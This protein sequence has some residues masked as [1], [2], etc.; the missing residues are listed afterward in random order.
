MDIA[1][2]LRDLGLERYEADFRENEIDWAVLP[3]LTADDLK[4]IGVTAVGHLR[5][6]LQAIAQLSATPAP[7]KP[8]PPGGSPL[9]T[10]GTPALAGGRPGAPLTGLDPGITGEGRVAAAA[11]A[12]R[13]QLTIMFCDL[14]GSTPLSSRLDPEDLRDVIGAYRRAVTE[15]IGAHH[16][17]VAEVIGTFEGFVAKYMGDGVLAYFGYPRG[18]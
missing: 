9:P 4:D 17:A 11:E 2:W 1:G 8:I 18:P 6:L 14:V 12:E 16:R 15:V 7:P 10:P 3:E 5:K 13:R